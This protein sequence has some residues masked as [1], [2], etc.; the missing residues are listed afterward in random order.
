MAPEW[1]KVGGWA[2]MSVRGWQVCVLTWNG[3][4]MPPGGR[5]GWG[6]GGKRVEA[7]PG[8]KLKNI[9]FLSCAPPMMVRMREAWPGQS[10]R[11]YCTS[12]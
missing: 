10:T 7:D 8:R 12:V 5:W 4:G 3:A 2:R 11:V 9:A 6:K 1:A